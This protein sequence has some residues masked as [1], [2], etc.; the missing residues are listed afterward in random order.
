MCYGQVLWRQIFLS[1]AVQVLDPFAT[2]ETPAD[3]ISPRNALGRL[4][5]PLTLDNENN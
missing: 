2:S 1:S 3:K 5:A 4:K